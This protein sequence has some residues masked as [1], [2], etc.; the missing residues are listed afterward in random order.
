MKVER[1]ADAIGELLIL[2]GPWA[3]AH[4]IERPGMDLVKIG[5]AALGEGAQQVAASRRTGC[6]P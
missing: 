6:R 4:E 5:I 1:L 3:A 2:R